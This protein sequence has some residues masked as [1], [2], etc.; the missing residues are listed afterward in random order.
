MAEI[1]EAVRDLSRSDK[2]NYLK[3][4][5]SDDKRKYDNYLAYKRVLKRR[6]NDRQKNNNCMKVIKEK[7]KKANPEKYRLQNIKDVANYKARKTLSA[8]AAA[9]VIS[10]N[11]KKYIER[12][13]ALKQSNRDKVITKSAAITMGNDMIDSL[14]NK[15][16]N[17]DFNHLTIRDFKKIVMYNKLS[18]GNSIIYDYNK[19]SKSQL[20]TEMN[21]IKDKLLI[22]PDL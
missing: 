19:M 10:D 18:N 13:N 21:E 22:P 6:N 20:L 12:I 8:D 5:S 9:K 16:K 3:T 15:N 11:I 17:T 4:L 14:L 1:F 7:A 2:I